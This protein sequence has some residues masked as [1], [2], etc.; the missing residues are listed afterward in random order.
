[1][2]ILPSGRQHEIRRGDSRAVL[3]E[4]GGGLRSYS[5]ADRELLDGYAKTEMCTV[6]RGQ[7]LIP[8]PN[9]IQDGRYTFEGCS[10][11]LAL[12]EPS[13]HH[14][15][16]GLARWA[17]WTAVR[18]REE[19]LTL[20]L[21]LHA[22]PGYPWVLT[23]E[24]EYTLDESGLRIT[25]SAA[26]AS[27]R[28]CPVGLGMHPYLRPPAEN[29]DECTL[30]IP[31]TTRMVGDERQIPVGWEPVD[32]SEV[33]FREPR[34][35][36][37]TAIDLGF[38]DLIRGD[39]GTARVELRGPD[40]TGAAVWLDRNLPHLMIFTGDTVEPS[41]RRRGLGVEPMTCAPD[42]FNNARDL[43]VLEPG[44]E[45]GATYGIQPL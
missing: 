14:A 32:G 38:T 4:T 16:H 15:I 7:Q 30:T 10:H 42:A 11:Q 23:L 45:A 41:R 43:I 18:R 37:A 44:S 20:S 3:V 29:L 31:A 8:W 17:N 25:M 19:S 34:Q 33:D 39:D 36:G 2:G 12:T 21:V 1:M 27:D 13:K 26:N 28:P 35:I 6:A 40:G 9:R 24:T 5:V 22:Q